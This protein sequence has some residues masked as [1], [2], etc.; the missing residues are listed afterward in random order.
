MKLSNLREKINFNTP[1]FWVKSIVVLILILIFYFI[2]MDR[3]TPYTSDAYV[4]AYV[5]QI[6]PQVEGRVIEVNVSNNQDVNKGDV[7]FQIDP[8]PYEYTVAQLNAELIQ[9]RQQIDQIKSEIISMDA[10]LKSAQAELNYAQK[11]YNDLV[12]LA[13]KNYIAKLE[14]DQAVDNLNTSKASLLSAE[15]NLQASKQKLEFTIDG[16][17]AL[18]RNAEAQ[19]ASAQYDLD[20]TTVYAPSDGIVTNLQLANGAYID[21]GTA[22]LTFVDTD[23]WWI[24]ANFKENSIGRIS[25][26]Q[27][28]R[29]SIAMYPGQTFK[30]SVESVD[31]GVSTG[32]GMPSGELPI[33]E[34]VNT[35][36]KIAQ[37]FPVRL[38]LDDQ[39]DNY[40]LRIGGSVTVT[41]FNDGGFILNGLARL[42]LKIGSLVDYLY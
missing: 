34:S 11:R 18:I 21:V 15:A 10:S 17:Y 30:A 29:V 36:V 12:P 28:A 20:Q 37:R 26:G 42:W 27:S 35:W 8:R 6:A 14:L 24:V 1:S 3:Y 33:V 22:V 5:V 9:T 38:K 19:L 40:N 25:A 41:V 39:H 32:Q 4:Q 23:S 16:D 31:W 13:E 7:L 2:L